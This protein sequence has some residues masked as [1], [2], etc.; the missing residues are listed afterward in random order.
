VNN[1]P[2]SQPTYTPVKTD[3]DGVL[4]SCRDI[5]HAHLKD[6]NTETSVLLK[7]KCK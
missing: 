6:E 2:V 1:Q 7:P 3:R 5:V 4:L